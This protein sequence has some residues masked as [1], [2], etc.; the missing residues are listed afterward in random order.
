MNKGENSKH[1]DIGS[2]GYQAEVLRRLEYKRAISPVTAACWK[3]AAAVS[4][5]TKFV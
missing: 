3:F 4:T 5:L 1:G 2:F